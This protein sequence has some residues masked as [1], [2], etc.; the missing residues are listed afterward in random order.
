MKRTSFLS[1]ASPPPTTIA[2][3]TWTKRKRLAQEFIA[4]L[5]SKPAHDIF[6]KFGWE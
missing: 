4:F 3:T 6:Q 1:P 5:K 2:I